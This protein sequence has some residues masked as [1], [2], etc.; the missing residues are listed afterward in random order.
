MVLAAREAGKLTILAGGL[1]PVNVQAAIETVQPDGVDVESGIK[2]ARG[3]HDPLLVGRFV[4]AAN[5][6]FEA[7]GLVAV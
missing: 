3:A 4:Q 1:T 2:D 6:A 5:A 7:V